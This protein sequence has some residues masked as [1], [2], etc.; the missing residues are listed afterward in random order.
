[1]PPAVGKKCIELGGRNR[2]GVKFLVYE[3]YVT[4]EQHCGSFS[5]IPE[6]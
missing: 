4:I 2:V 5:G 6:N 1:M 3:R